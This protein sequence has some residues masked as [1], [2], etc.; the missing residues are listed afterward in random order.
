VSA[1]VSARPCGRNGATTRASLGLPRDKGAVRM[2]TRWVLI[3]LAL[4]PDKYGSYHNT[5]I[6]EVAFDAPPRVGEFL[7]VQPEQVSENLVFEVL[8]VVHAPSDRASNAG[9]LFLRRVGTALEF[10]DAM[11]RRMGEK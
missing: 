11:R 1:A 7:D 8:A 6:G 4:S 3:E 10:H 5:S 2:V 9:D